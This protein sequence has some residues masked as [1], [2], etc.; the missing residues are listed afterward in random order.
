MTRI[1]GLDLSLTSSGIALPDGTTTTLR[2][3]TALPDVRLNQLYGRLHRLL[4]PHRPQ[5]ALIEG[6]ALHAPGALGLT[7]LAEWGGVARLVLRRMRCPYVVVPPTSLKLW[8]CGH[9]HAN[10]D[11]MID[12]AKAAGATPANDDEADAYLLRAIGLLTV[13]DIDLFQDPRERIRRL[14]LADDLAW[15]D[16]RDLPSSDVGKGE[17]ASA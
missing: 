3:D 15:P 14:A 10:K 16:L 5:L 4:E 2:P 6:Y 17:V 1:V 12:A 13:D 8:A 7:R 9:G 11:R